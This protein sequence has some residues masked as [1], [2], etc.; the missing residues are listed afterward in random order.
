[1]AD[2]ESQ[3]PRAP[4]R[5]EQRMAA[6][7]KI[8]RATSLPRMKDGRRLRPMHVEAVS[9]GEKPPTDE[10]KVESE[11]E[12]QRSTEGQIKNPESDEAK[13][14]IAEEHRRPSEPVSDHLLPHTTEVPADVE[15]DAENPDT[16]LEE[17]PMSS[18]PGATKK[19]RSRSRS[20]SRGSRDLKSKLK[21]PPSP[22]PQLA[23]DSSQDETSVIPSPM[24]L[25]MLSPLASPV[26]HFPFLQQSRILRTPTPLPPEMSLFYPG[27]SPPTPLP[28]LADLQR[29][30]MRSN[31]VGTAAAGR[32]LA[33]HK[34]TG[35]T[36]SYDPSPSPTPPPLISKLGRNNTVSGGERIA[37]R[38]NMLNRL[39]TRMT[40]EADAEAASGAEEKHVTPQ[41]TKR[42]NRRRSKGSS[43]INSTTPVSDSDFPS[44]D[45]NT[46]AVSSSSLPELQDQYVELRMRSTTP[47]QA[48]SSRTQS[49]ERVSDASPPPLP[50]LPQP[51]EEHERPEPQ[52]RRSVVIE[53]PDDDVQN[54]TPTDPQQHYATLP[55]SPQRTFQEIDGIRTHASNTPSNGSSSDSAPASAVGVP[56]IF[57]Q[58][59]TSRNEPFP[60]SPFTSPVKARPLS[61]YEEEQVLYPATTAR[62]RTPYANAVQIHDREISWIASPGRP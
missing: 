16:E 10:E 57:S 14:I 15:L 41:H 51:P 43:A 23:G 9:E 18:S 36:E 32:I 13:D 12:K 37:A 24:L 11:T 2:Q 53:D 50:S 3:P 25:P 34:L 4:S 21:P 20:R 1:M 8:R 27:P 22:M 61:D 62:P 19:R 7:A 45:G 56:V 5:A 60:T 47:N 55:G 42:R 59:A 54:D 35:G 33:M 30:L 6:V 17:R 58:R 46:P 26:P 39:G 38:Q 31:S 29:G 44:T 48:L 49:S 40:R 52:R 28:T